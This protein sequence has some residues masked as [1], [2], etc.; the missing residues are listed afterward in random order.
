[1]DRGTRALSPGSP[2]AKGKGKKY[3]VPGH[4]SPF[5]SGTDPGSNEKDDGQQ[6]ETR[7]ASKD[8]DAV[9]PAKLAPRLRTNCDDKDI[10]FYIAHQASSPAANPARSK[11]KPDP[12][13]TCLADRI[14]EE[15]KSPSQN[16]TEDNQKS[17]GHVWKRLNSAS[18]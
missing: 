2:N 4:R 8:K 17:W 6:E 3:Q 12:S 14:K 16:M 9:P 1:M 10:K 15:A 5:K 11:P 18:G 7:K 13:Q